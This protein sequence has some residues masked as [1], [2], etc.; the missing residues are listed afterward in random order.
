MFKNCI[1]RLI[2]SDDRNL[3]WVKVCRCFLDFI[4]GMAYCCYIMSLSRRRGK[5][6]ALL[7]LNARPLFIDAL[8][9]Y[10]FKLVSNFWFE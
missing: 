10:Q 7:T 5:R 3:I 1:D 4:H 9:V 8:C 2:S 6:A